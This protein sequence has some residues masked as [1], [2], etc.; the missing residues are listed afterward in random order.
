VT[1]FRSI[2]LPADTHH[3]ASLRSF[4]NAAATNEGIDPALLHPLELAADEVVTNIIDH[5][6]TYGDIICSCAIDRDS[7]AVICE[8]SWLSDEPFVPEVF[9]E[10]EHIRRRLEAREPGGL[11]VFLIHSLVDEI[12]YDYH[13]GRSGVRLVKRF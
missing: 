6:A 4:I 13:D 7:H 8:I 3:L 12:E 9:P 1:S 10:P 11:G 5:A 2:S